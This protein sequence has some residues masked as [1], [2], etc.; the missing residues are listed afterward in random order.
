MLDQ[1]TFELGLLVT[2]V[3]FRVTARNSGAH[4][5]G[6]DMT[7][8][9]PAITTCAAAAREREREPRAERRRCAVAARECRE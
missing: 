6:V 3:P 2:R 9:G 4:L 7:F 8:L 1:R 5:R